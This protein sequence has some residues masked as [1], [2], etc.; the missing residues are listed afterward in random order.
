[1]RLLDDHFS[2]CGDTTRRLNQ[3]RGY[4]KI[5]DPKDHIAHAIAGL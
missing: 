3:S 4:I 5:V 2:K 1:M